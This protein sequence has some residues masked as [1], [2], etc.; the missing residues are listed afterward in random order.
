MDKESAIRQCVRCVTITSHAQTGAWL[1][2]ASIRRSL[3]WSIIRSL[4]F[5][6]CLWPCGLCCLL[7]SGNVNSQSCSSNGTPSISRRRVKLS[8]RSSSS[9]YQRGER[10][11]SLAYVTF[12]DFL[13]SNIFFFTT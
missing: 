1:S 3:I 8:G 10:I 5:S 9:R 13:N 11:R 2:R 12:L 6:Q 7:S 4:S